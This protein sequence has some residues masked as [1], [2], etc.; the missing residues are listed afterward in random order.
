GS[1]FLGLVCKFSSLFYSSLHA[2]ETPAA[3][4]GAPDRP[5]RP[6]RVSGRDPQALLGRGDPRAAARQRR[7]PGPFADHAGARS[8]PGADRPPA[9]RDPALQDRER[10]ET[11]GRA[12]P[13]PVPP[14]GRPDPA[15]A[16]AGRRPGAPADGEG[17]RRAPRLD[18][19]QVPLLAHVRLAE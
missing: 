1:S 15:A 12:R 2:P 19:V 3:A 17:S 18:A 7:A 14:A 5:R 4:G 8:R 13:T 16:R 9:D 11:E 6:C 10:G